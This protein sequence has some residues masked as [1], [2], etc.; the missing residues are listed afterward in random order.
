MTDKKQNEQQE[1]QQQEEN[2]LRDL[3]VPEEQAG[4]V[5]GGLTVRKSGK[6]QLEY[7]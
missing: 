1:Q 5:K 3:D 6:E 2:E 4:D 7:Y